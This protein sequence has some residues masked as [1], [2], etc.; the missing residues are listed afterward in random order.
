MLIS[1]IDNFVK[2]K[3]IGNRAQLHP[4]FVLLGILGG[5]IM[6]GLIGVILGP[7]ILALFVTFVEIYE[8]TEFD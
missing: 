5:L 8:E 1:T 7:L 6:F 2:P 4:A 3:L